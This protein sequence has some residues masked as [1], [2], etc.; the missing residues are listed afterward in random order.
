MESGVQNRMMEWSFFAAKV[1]KD[2]FNDLEFEAVFT[3]VTVV[4]RSFRDLGRRE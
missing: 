3:D 4:S 2:P 1:H